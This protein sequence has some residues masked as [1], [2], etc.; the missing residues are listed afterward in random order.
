MFAAAAA[1]V[2]T[3]AGVA[4]ADDEPETGRICRN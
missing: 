3:F 4:M 2:C 1:A